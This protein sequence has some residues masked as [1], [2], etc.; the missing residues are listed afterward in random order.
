MAKI[1][2]KVDQPSSAPLLNDPK[3][4][5]QLSKKRAELH[6]AQKNLGSTLSNPHAIKAIKKDIARILTKMNAKPGHPE[7]S[8]GSHPNNQ[9]T[10]GAK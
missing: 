4:V 9:P 5:D 2:P 10:K 6:E 7:R 3:I 1:T 8:E